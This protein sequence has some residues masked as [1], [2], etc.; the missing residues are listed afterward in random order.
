MLK[1]NRPN[2]FDAV[3]FKQSNQHGILA[4]AVKIRYIDRVQAFSRWTRSISKICVDT[5]DMIE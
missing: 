2:E 5:I 1:H 4:E 3:Y